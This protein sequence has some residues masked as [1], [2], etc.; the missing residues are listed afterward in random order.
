MQDFDL[1]AALSGAGVSRIVAALVHDP[2]EREEAYGIVLCH[3]ANHTSGIKAASHPGPYLRELT[4][5]A[6]RDHRRQQAE[7]RDREQPFNEEETITGVSDGYA[8]RL[9]HAWS[10]GE[11]GVSGG[12]GTIG[13]TRATAFPTEATLTRLAIAHEVRTWPAEERRAVSH[14]CDGISGYRELA[15]LHG[16]SVERARWFVTSTITRKLRKTLGW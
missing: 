10:R 14:L 3:A 11:G 7:L 15:A 13:G 8:D 5:N 9:A 4:R 12:F 2:E 16:W 6:V 1:S